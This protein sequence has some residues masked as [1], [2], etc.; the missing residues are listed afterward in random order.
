MSVCSLSIAEYLKAHALS[1]AGLF[2][3]PGNYEMIYRLRRLYQVDESTALSWG[4]RGADHFVMADL[5]KL[6]FRELAEPI[7]PY[8][9]YQKMIGVVGKGL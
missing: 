7:I 1:T 9:M 3:I 5:L 6:F 4:V 2:Q 8:A